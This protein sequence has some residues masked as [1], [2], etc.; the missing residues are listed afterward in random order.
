MAT[1]KT[2]TFSSSSKNR[3]S[4]MPWLGSA[5]IVDAIVTLASSLDMTTTAEGVET[6]E[7]LEQVR[8]AGCTAAQGYYLGRPR[9]AADV[10]ADLSSTGCSIPA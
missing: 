9:P 5:A 8:R 3:T 7:Q 6:I 1:R 2:T 10:F 4:L